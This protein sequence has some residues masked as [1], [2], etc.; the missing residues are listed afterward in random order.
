MGL[1]YNLAWSWTYTHV[2]QK[3]KAAHC[4]VLENTNPATER[5]NQHNLDPQK[6]QCGNLRSKG[7][8]SIRAAGLQTS[9]KCLEK[10]NTWI[11]GFG[12]RCVH[13]SKEHEWN[14]FKSKYPWRTFL[15]AVE[16]QQAVSCSDIVCW[17]SV[18][19]LSPGEG[20][21]RH[22]SPEAFWRLGLGISGYL[23]WHVQYW[24]L[25]TIFI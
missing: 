10:L 6:S 21:S 9:Q 22:C 14:S 13:S 7:D 15:S 20:S 5:Q 1:H 11:K 4:C 19:G 23:L 8:L 25:I 3:T 16:G 12:R 17:V 2:P 24:S 18:A